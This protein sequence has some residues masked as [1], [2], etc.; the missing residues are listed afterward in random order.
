[1]MQD[2]PNTEYLICERSGGWLTI[3]INRPEVRNALTNDVFAELDAVADFALSDPT[4]RGITLQGKGGTFSAGGDLKMFRDIF[5]GNAPDHQ[6]V[7]TSSKLYGQVYQKINRLPQVVVMLVEGAAIAGGL[8]L[9]CTADVVVVTEDA[10]FSLT[11][12]TLGIPPAQV[13]PLVVKVV[14]LKTARRL[15]LTASRFN[16]SEARELGLADF[17][18]KTRD[19]LSIVEESIKQ[20]VLKCAPNA[21]AITKDIILTSLSLDEDS[22]I[23]KVAEHFADCMLG[24]EGREGVAAYLEKRPPSWR[25]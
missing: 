15:M 14:G 7:V 12:T 20:Q 1:M 3:W 21:N 19:E 2:F 17:V 9:L 24:D 4:L 6:D 16:G 25:K 13:A 22:I 5:Q 10:K 23:G 11:E 18:V 8:G